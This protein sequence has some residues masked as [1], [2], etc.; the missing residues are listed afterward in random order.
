MI[1]ECKE[2]HGE[3]K[4]GSIPLDLSYGVFMCIFC[5]SEDFPIEKEPSANKERE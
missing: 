5:G 3:F 1:Y 2:C 4:E